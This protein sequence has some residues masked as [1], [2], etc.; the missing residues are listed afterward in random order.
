M[1]RREFLELLLLGSL[2]RAGLADSATRFDFD[3]ALEGQGLQA[4]LALSEGRKSYQLWLNGQ[5]DSA[6][7]RT[8]LASARLNLVQGHRSVARLATADLLPLFRK[9]AAEQTAELDFL[10][11]QVRSGQASKQSSQELQARW[12]ASLRT[13][14]LWLKSRRLR[15]PTLVKASRTLKLKQYFQWRASLL[16]LMEEELAL[17]EALA[18][19]FLDQSSLLSNLVSRALRLYQRGQGVRPPAM[20][21][22]AHQVFLERLAALARLSE[23]AEAYLSDPSSDAA[24]N[25]REDE[26]H[27]SDLV[28][29]G[30]QESLSVLSSLLSK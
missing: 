23:S 5:L 14:S 7:A 15:L 1:R 6:T 10:A 26:T 21:H 30:N 12:L 20:L 3:L 8:R 13:Q 28:M 24:S 19:G 18:R 16:G 11:G 17:A 29:R 25:L 22:R 9:W 4:D 27:Y 2:A